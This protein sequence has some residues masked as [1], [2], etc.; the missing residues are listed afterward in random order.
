MIMSNKWV[1]VGGEQ[2]QQMNISQAPGTSVTA[3]ASNL[4]NLQNTIQIEDHD[5]LIIDNQQ[6][7]PTKVRQEEEQK[8]VFNQHV[9]I[10]QI[11]QP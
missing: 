11:N 8:A 5:L 3:N 4:V 7:K 9:N 10:N 6:L 2:Q 1:N